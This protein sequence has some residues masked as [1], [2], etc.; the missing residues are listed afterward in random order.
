MYLNNSP[1]TIDIAYLTQISLVAFRTADGQSAQHNEKK[2]NDV[3]Y[4]PSSK[5]STNSQ[6]MVTTRWYEFDNARNNSSAS[7]DFSNKNNQWT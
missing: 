1:V 2:S 3:K 5:L 4:D 6:K 7:Y